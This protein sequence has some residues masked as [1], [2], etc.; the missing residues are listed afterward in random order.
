MKKTGGIHA[1]TQ[2]RILTYRDYYKPGTKPR[3][4]L[5]LLLNT[6]HTRAEVVRIGP[7][8]INRDGKLSMHRQKAGVGFAIPLLPALVAELVLLPRTEPRDR[9]HNHR[10]R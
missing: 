1:W 10:R 9:A 6:G 2:D 8:H 3:R 7:Q 4:A 5:E